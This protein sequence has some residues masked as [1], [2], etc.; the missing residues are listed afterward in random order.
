M[1]ITGKNGKNKLLFQDQKIL[2]YYGCN[3]MSSLDKD[4]K[5]I[6]FFESST[7]LKNI[8]KF[9]PKSGSVII[10][11]DYKSHKGSNSR[12]KYSS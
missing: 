12:E 4:Y 5:N 7:D 6:V 1:I 2:N 8:E 3:Y 11:F 9:I 10:T